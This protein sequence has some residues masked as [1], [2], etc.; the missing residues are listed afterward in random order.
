MRGDEELSRKGYVWFRCGIKRKECNIWLSNFLSAVLDKLPFPHQ[1]VEV[2]D[3]I[4][5]I[6][7]L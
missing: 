3:N 7:F 1:R 6:M 2:N 4:S 5:L